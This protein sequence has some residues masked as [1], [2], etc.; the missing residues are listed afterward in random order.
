VAAGSRGSETAAVAGEERDADIPVCESNRRQECL[1]RAH[2]PEIRPVLISFPAGRG[3]LMG[4][5]L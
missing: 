1:R 2:A 3:I 4:K 5:P